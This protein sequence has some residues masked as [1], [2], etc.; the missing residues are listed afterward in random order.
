M[1][2]PSIP[3]EEVARSQQILYNLGRDSSGF[4]D[5]GYRDCDPSVKGYYTGPMKEVNQ[6]SD[7]SDGVVRSKHILSHPGMDSSTFQ[8]SGNRD[9]E[10]ATYD[11]SVK[12]YYTG[13]VKGE[14]Q[15]SVPPD[16]VVRSQQIISRPDRDSR[17]LQNF[18][19]RH[20]VQVSSPAEGMY[21][22]LVPSD[23]V[24]RSQPIRSNPGQKTS[25]LQESGYRNVEQVTSNPSPKAHFIQPVEVMNQSSVSTDGVVRSQPNLSNPAKDSSTLQDSGHRYLEQVA[26]DPSPKESY[27]EPV[28][29]VNQPSVSPEEMVSKPTLSNPRKKNPKHQDSRTDNLVQVSSDF[30]VKGYTVDPVTEGNQSSVPPDGVVGSQ[31]NLSNPAKDSSTHQDSRYKNLEQVASDPSPKENLMEPVKLMNQSSVPPEEM[32]SKPALSNTRKENHEHQDSRTNNLVQVSS[33]LSV[34]GYVMDP[35]TE[36]NQSSVLPDGLVGSQPN[37]SNPAKD[38]ST[39]QDSGYRDPEPVASDSSPKENLMKPVKVMNQS[40]VPPDEIVSK[41]TL[42]NPRKENHEHQDSRTNNLVQ[43]SSNLSVKGHVMD[44]VTVSNQ[45]S[46]PPD[47][48]VR[49][50]PNL[51]NLDK[52]NSGLQDSGYRDLEPVSSNPLPK[53]YD[54]DLEKVMD[55]SSVPTDELAR[56]QAILSNPGKDNYSHQDSVISNLVQVSS[57]HLVKG[58]IMDP[59]TERNRSS[60]PLNETARSQQILVN[61]ENETSSLQDSKNRDQLHVSSHPLLKRNDMDPNKVAGTN[62]KNVP[63]AQQNRGINP[64]KE[65]SGPK[66]SGSSDRSV[67]GYCMDPDKEVNQPSVPPN[68]MVRS[69]PIVF[70][71]RPENSGFPDSEYRDRVPVST[72]RLPKGHYMELVKVMNQTSIPSEEV[73]RSQQIPY[74]PERSLQ[75]SQPIL[76]K[77]NSVHPDSRE[78]V[79][80][81]SDHLARGY[82]KEVVRVMNQPSVPQNGMERPQPIPYNRDRNNSN[83]QDPGHRGRVQ[84]SSDRSPNQNRKEPIKGVHQPSAPQN[85]MDRSQP[86]LYNRD[87]DNPNFQDPGYR[88]RVQVASNRSPYEYRKERIEG[89]NQPPVPQNGMNRSQPIPYNQD[90]DNPNFQDSRHRG[91]VQVLSDRSPNEYRKEPIERLNKPSVQQNGMER[92]QPILYNRDRDNSNFQDSRHRDR[93][94]VSSNRAPYEYRKE[95]IEVVNQPSVPQN[96]MNRS[97][98]IPYS[99]DRDNSNFQDSRHRDRVQVS[100]NR[101][102]YEYRKER[103]EVVNQPSVPQNGM[104]RSQ[105]IPYNRDRDNPIFQDSGYRDGVQVLSDRLPTEYYKEHVKGGNRPSVPPDEVPR[106]QPII[107]NPAMESSSPREDSVFSNPGHVSSKFLANGHYKEPVEVNNLPSAPPDEVSQSGFSEKVRLSSSRSAEEHNPAAS[108][109]DK[110]APTS[111]EDK[112]NSL[113]MQP[114]PNLS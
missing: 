113:P 20:I 103:I 21:K 95:R 44:P 80:V 63:Q 87:R 89:V 51:P 83:F 11:P 28:K 2:H 99:R 19:S 59:V 82:N 35:V 107:F 31:P 69:E 68:G 27:M 9:L 65:N 45:S 38:S 64:A 61:P 78:R 49:S 109:D 8:N 76:C 102:P 25:K 32:V 60:V 106:S 70:N 14:N 43:V 84:V 85:G 54:M 58:H 10:Q 94:Q 57:D 91:R 6:P 92:S 47:G 26:S 81:S 17:N 66:D 53:R 13:P 62:F 75:R 74:N 105:P 79:Q 96:G 110:D 104:N 30:S 52:E 112:R 72:D 41:P 73:A 67:K 48:V 36:G 98:P 90:R 5:S 111:R 42:S 24:P 16:E 108:I 4:Q 1:N 29:V 86:V 93:V 23:D 46:V 12:E 114:S 97:Q 22:P 100:S 3:P 101:S 88:D 50:Q 40:S 56:T 39:L 71:S 55:Q 18:E 34:K 7:P 37:L 33:D 77:E 15:P